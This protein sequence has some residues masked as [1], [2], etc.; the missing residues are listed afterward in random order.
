MIIEPVNRIFN[1]LY[2]LSMLQGGIYLSEQRTRAADC[3][4][5][6]LRRA[7]ENAFGFVL[8]LFLDGIDELPAETQIAYCVCSRSADSLN[9]RDLQRFANSNRRSIGGS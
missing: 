4:F 3:G 1:V 8:G 7:Q 2:P 9:C 5:L 6:A